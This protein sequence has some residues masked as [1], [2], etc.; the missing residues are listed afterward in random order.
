MIRKP[1]FTGLRCSGLEIATGADGRSVPFNDES[2]SPLE[3]RRERSRAEL[4]IDLF[5]SA[6][7]IG[8]LFAQA[9]IPE[10]ELRDE[11]AWEKERE[12]RRWHKFKTP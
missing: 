11:E 7:S 4:P 12:T 3:E 9:K 10:P 8:W 6:N 2:R 5:R 1:V